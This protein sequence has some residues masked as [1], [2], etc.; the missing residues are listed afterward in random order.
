[1]VQGPEY[2]TLSAAGQIR[3]KSSMQAPDRAVVGGLQP[4][5]SSYSLAP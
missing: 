1:M 2:T 3:A 4:A 5:I